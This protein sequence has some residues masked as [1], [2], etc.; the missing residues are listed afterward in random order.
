MVWRLPDCQAEKAD[1]EPCLS[2]RTT[3]YHRV[4]A[5]P[6]CSDLPRERWVGSASRRAERRGIGHDANLLMATVSRNAP[7]RRA[8]NAPSQPS[9]N[10]RIEAAP[11]RPAVPA[12]R[13]WSQKLITVITTEAPKTVPIV[14]RS[15]REE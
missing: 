15:I 11:G 10:A 2:H 6:G 5:R 3:P 1:S 7:V 13:L 12:R 9:T 14:R 4:A 8:V